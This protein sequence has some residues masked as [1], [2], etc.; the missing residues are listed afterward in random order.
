MLPSVGAGVVGSSV[1][2]DKG[3]FK[4][5]MIANQIPVVEMIVVLR[6]ENRKRYGFCHGES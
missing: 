4:D 2:M 5:V 1:G 3:L 6:T